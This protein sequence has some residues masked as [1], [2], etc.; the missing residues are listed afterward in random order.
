VRLLSLRRARPHPWPVG[1]SFHQS[2]GAELA[3][4]VW[5]GD[6]LK[7]RLERPAGEA[8]RIVVASDRGMPREA[9]VAGKRARLHEGAGGSVVLPIVAASDRTA[10][11]MRW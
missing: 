5:S 11:E 7:G 10:W 3:G 6:A 9:R 4:V 1:T 8:G 2:C